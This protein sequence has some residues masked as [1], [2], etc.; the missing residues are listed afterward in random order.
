M[1]VISNHVLSHQSAVRHL[2]LVERSAQEP[3][4]VLKQVQDD[5]VPCKSHQFSIPWRLPEHLFIP[6]RNMS[7]QQ[8]LFLNSAEL[9]SYKVNR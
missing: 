1:V 8:Y 4:G 5:D 7:N 6:G 3:K 9:L 2:D